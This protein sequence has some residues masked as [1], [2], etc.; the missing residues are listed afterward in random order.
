M[1]LGREAPLQ[2]PFRAVSDEGAGLGQG[3]GRDPLLLQQHVEGADQV[4]G[5]VHQGPVQVEGD[6]GAG[7]RCKVEHRAGSIESA[8]RFG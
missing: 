6:R 2:Q 7:K 4:V 3:Q 5:G 8:R 1:A